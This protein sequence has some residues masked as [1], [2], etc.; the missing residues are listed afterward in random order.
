MGSI[1]W[2]LRARHC[3]SNEDEK[4]ISSAFEGTAGW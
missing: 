3:I 2:F 1:E 4:D